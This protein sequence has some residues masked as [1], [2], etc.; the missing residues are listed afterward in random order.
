[1]KKSTGTRI[2]IS[3]DKSSAAKKVIIRDTVFRKGSVLN[4]NN[5]FYREEKVSIGFKVRR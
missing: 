3:V 1:M 2:G 5:N 4:S